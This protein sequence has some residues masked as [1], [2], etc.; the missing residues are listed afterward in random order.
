[1]KTCMS[2]ISTRSS[3]TFQV[4][5]LCLTKSIEESIDVRDEISDRL[6]N[7]YTIYG[8]YS[9]KA[10]DIVQINIFLSYFYQNTHHHESI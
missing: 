10:P 8:G 6:F 5:R 9:E 1:M 3:E 2:D 7:L 4:S